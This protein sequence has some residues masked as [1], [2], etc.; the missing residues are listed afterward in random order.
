MVVIG[1]MWSLCWREYYIVFPVASGAEVL[2]LG[3]GDLRIDESILRDD[4]GKMW[5]QNTR[6]Y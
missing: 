1:S 2:G 6:S 5:L 3:K 4:N